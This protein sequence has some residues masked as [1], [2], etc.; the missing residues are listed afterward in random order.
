MNAYHMPHNSIA[1]RWIAFF[2]TGVL[3]HDNTMLGIGFAC[4]VSPHKFAIAAAAGTYVNKI[5]LYVICDETKQ[6]ITH[7]LPKHFINY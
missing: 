7:S 1:F 3:I 6:L 2:T 4:V 5:I